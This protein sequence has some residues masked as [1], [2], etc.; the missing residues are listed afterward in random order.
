[1]QDKT[2][3]AAERRAFWQAHLTNWRQSGLN[4]AA[5]CREQ[6][7]NAHRFRW[8]KRQLTVASTAEKSVSAAF[9]AV[10]VQPPRLIPHAAH[11]SGIALQLDT[12]V[13]VE[14][15]VGFDA[16]TL[17]AVLQTLRR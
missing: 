3:T 9:L 16:P 14:V 10:E 5:Y 1:M 11:D 12:G 17:Q 7:L 6:G 2:S 8:W 15:A 4:Q 13:R